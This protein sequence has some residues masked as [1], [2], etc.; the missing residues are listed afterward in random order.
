MAHHAARRHNLAVLEVVGDIEQRRNED[1]IG[2]DAL[3]LNLIATTAARQQLRQKSAF[4][5]G[6]DD[7]GVLDELCA[8]QTQHFRAEILRPIR[9]ADTATSD[10]RKAEMNAF[11]AR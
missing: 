3:L 10:G 4:G 1:A 7:H 6:G 11:H 9:P 8:Y 2:R 5:A